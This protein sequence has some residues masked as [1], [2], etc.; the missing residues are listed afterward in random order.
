MYAPTPPHRLDRGF[1][2][3]EMMVVTT[4]VGILAAIAVPNYIKYQRTA[5]IGATIA[6]LRN[7][8]QGFLAFSISRDAFPPDTEGALPAEMARY[9]DPVT[10]ARETPIGGS[11]EWEGPDAF[12]YAGISIVPAG[13]VPD[14]ELLTI[15]RTLDDGD[16]ATGK[17]RIGTSG[18]PTYVLSP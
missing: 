1:S 16:L 14:D 10:W 2:L 3:V 4:I 17:F 7:F 6:E 12:P 8:S 13:V 9:I 18:R 15:D 11:Y 5:R